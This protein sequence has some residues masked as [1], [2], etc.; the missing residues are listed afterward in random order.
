MV[1]N[2][3]TEAD[4]AL[5]FYFRAVRLAEPVQLALLHKYG[6]SL[7]DLHALRILRD[8]GPVPISCFA[9]ALEVS[10]S[11]MTGL[12][13]RLEQRG[14]LRREACAEDRRVTMVSVTRNGIEALDDDDL[15][16]DSLPGRRISELSKEEQ[17][18]LA[19]I[20]GRLVSDD[21]EKSTVAAKES[22]RVLS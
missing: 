5:R 18:Q 4:R 11:T 7:A 20:L 8:L 16:R 12:V 6:V 21:A 15:F 19:D 1:K 22:I 2:A 17:R 10:R 14:L 13:D 9:D 3:R